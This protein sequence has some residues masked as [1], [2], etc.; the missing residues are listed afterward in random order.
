MYWIILLIIKGFS[1]W[2]FVLSVYICESLCPV[3]YIKNKDSSSNSI[4]PHGIREQIQLESRSLKMGD[5]S[6]SKLIKESSARPTETIYTLGSGLDSSTFQLAA[7]KLDEKKCCEWVRAKRLAIKG[8]DKMGYLTSKAQAARMTDW[9]TLLPICVGKQENLPVASWFANL[10]VPS[11]YHTFM[12]LAPQKM[13]GHLC[14]KLFLMETTPH[15]SSKTTL[16]CCGKWNKVRDVNDYYVE[17]K[18]WLEPEANY[19]EWKV[20]ECCIPSKIGMEKEKKV[21]ISGWLE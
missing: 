17:M 10:M 2:F 18:A 13:S 11:I 19:E 3:E 16:S 14:V 4:N 8:R 21:W 1:H 9:V 7:K 12:F 15:K 6:D 20:H 5:T